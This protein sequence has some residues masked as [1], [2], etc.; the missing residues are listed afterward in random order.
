MSL[1][2]FQN[3][4]YSVG[5]QWRPFLTQNVIVTGGIG[6]LTPLGGFAEIYRRETL[7]SGFV[8]LTLLY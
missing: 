5:A 7:Y 2:L 3:V 4:D 1:I 8:A 6:L